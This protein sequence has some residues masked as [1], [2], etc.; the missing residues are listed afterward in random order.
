[1]ANSGNESD[2]SKNIKAGISIGGGAVIGGTAGIILGPPGVIVGAAV[3]GV[4]GGA[5]GGVVALFSGWL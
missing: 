3:G 2:E 4:V 5:V 1:M